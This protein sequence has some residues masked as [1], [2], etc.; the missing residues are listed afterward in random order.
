MKITFIGTGT[1][2]CTTR[3]NTG[4]IQFFMIT[5]IKCAIHQITF[6][7]VT[8]LKTTDTHMGLEDYK[9]L[10]IKYPNC[11]FYAIHRADYNTNGIS[12]VKFPND[13][14]IL[15]IKGDVKKWKF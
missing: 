13:G 4:V 7:Y 8:G 5:I 11:T 14:D 9:E 1:M 6:F 3:S 10:Y 12:S 15:E 2:W